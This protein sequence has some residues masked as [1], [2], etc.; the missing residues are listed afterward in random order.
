MS[1]RTRYSI[2]NILIIQNILYTEVY[3][4]SFLSNIFTKNIK[5]FV[6][7]P[8]ATLPQKQT[9]EAAGYDIYSCLEEPIVIAP[10]ER[11]VIPTGLIIIIPKGY[12]LS[13]RPRSGLALKYGITLPNTP[14][15]IDSDFRGELKVAMINL[16]NESF[17]I[18]HQM[19][20]AQMLLE[21]SF[22][23]KFTILSDNT[24]I[25]DTQR[26]IQGFGSTGIT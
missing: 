1:I 4:M 24:K 7:N 5:V 9:I 20:I 3:F 21:K 13:I 2:F 15:T 8:K 23:M 17:T 19:R 10:T 25:Q 22:K 6:T 16:G 14:G 26:S 12:L 18:T 11:V